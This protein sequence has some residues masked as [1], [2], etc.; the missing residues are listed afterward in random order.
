MQ[1]SQGLK[2]AEYKCSVINTTTQVFMP[3]YAAWFLQKD[4]TYKVPFP[5]I[6]PGPSWLSY[7]H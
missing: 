1:E 4:Y 3:Q 7:V 6:F 5:Q 2:T